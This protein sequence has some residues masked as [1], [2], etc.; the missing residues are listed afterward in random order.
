MSIA[1][2]GIFQLK[3]RTYGMLTYVFMKDDAFL[4]VSIA[5]RLSAAILL[6]FNAHEHPGV[7]LQACS[8]REIT[9]K[10][11]LTQDT[12]LQQA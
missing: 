5:R 1:L 6:L 8:R 12:G 11:M 2:K 9:F 10:A 4:T 7:S 3:S